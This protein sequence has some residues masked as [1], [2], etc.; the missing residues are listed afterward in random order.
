M[1][2][3]LWGPGLYV[4]F[5]IVAVDVVVVVIVVNAGGVPAVVDI[6][7]RYSYPPDTPIHQILLYTMSLKNVLD[8]FCFL[9]PYILRELCPHGTYAAGHSLLIYREAGDLHRDSS[10]FGS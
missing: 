9:I 8:I 6:Y 3:K 4:R 5:V 7:T 10:T 1:Q 2:P